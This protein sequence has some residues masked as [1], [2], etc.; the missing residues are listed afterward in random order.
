MQLQ[1]AFDRIADVP[2]TAKKGMVAAAR[3][4][5]L[6]RGVA[7]DALWSRPADCR[8]F[9]GRL[10]AGDDD[11][12]SEQIVPGAGF[13]SVPRIGISFVVN[14]L[15]FTLLYHWL[16]KEPIPFRDALRGGIA[17]ALVWEIGA[18]IL[19]LF[20]IG[21]R[22]TDAYGVVGSFIALMLWCYYAVA[23]LLLGAEYMQ[24]CR[25]G[26][27]PPS[28][29]TKPGRKIKSIATGWANALA[30]IWSSFPTA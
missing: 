30:H 18:Q 23:V 28:S 3:L 19:G 12:Y 20:L 25:E 14:T 4:V 6:E 7:S 22:Y 5:L 9:R 10:G 8:G 29:G 13:C 24:V 2:A 21:T 11:H 27:G 26:K 17:A 16:P 1:R 15:L